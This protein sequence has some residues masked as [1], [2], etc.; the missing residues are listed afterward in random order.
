MGSQFYQVWG[1]MG[2]DGIGMRFS[3]GW[4]A[5]EV[6]AG[7]WGGN[8]AGGVGTGFGVAWSGGAGAAQWRR[9]GPLFGDDSHIQRAVRRSEAK[10]AHCRKKSPLGSW[11]SRRDLS[12]S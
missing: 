12:F 8:D 4:G 6:R 10:S 2:R 7:R 3:S 1:E 5:G 9:S 11:R